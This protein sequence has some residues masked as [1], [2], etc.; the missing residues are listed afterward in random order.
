MNSKSSSKPRN[1]LFAVL[2]VGLLTPL[3]A[4]EHKMPGE[5]SSAMSMP[6]DEM[7]D[8]KG[9]VSGAPTVQVSFL[10]TQ[11]PVAGE[12]VPVI[13]KLTTK[14]GKPVTS[15]DLEVAHTK[16]VHLLIVDA[17]LTSYTH[18]HP[19][20]TAP[21][22]WTFT[23]HPKLGGNYT[24]FADLHPKTTGKQ[25]YARTTFTVAGETRKIDLATNL[26]AIVD[27]YHF[28]LKIPADQ[29]LTDG[30]AS[31]VSVHVTKPGGSPARN[32]EPIMGAFAHGVAFTPDLQSV[33]HVHPMGKEP[34]SKDDS[35]GPDLRF[36]LEPTKAGF[37]KFYVQVQIRGQDEFAS[38]GLMAAPAK[39]DALDS[40]HVHHGMNMTY[41]CPMHPEVTSSK[42]G[43][44]CPKCGMTLVLQK[45]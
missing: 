34:K 30:V 41:A 44:E 40:A 28:D 11:P 9:E 45:N 39:S 43:Q 13:V 29:P 21:G 31:E 14:E 37:F 23:F 7:S 26:T 3:S 1:L 6:G 32:L 10:P 2:T 8:G 24:V 5:N 22:E 27:G 18:E 4:Q 42:S 33:V 38:F 20:E 25:E 16:L 15:A 17:S 19:I 12:N 35:G 36:H